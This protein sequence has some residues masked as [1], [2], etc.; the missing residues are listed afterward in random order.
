MRRM[1]AGLPPHISARFL[2]VDDGSTDGTSE[3]VM[4]QSEGLD[5]TVLRHEQPLGPG[6]AFATLFAH[7]DGRI[8]ADDYVA[9]MEGDNTSRL[10]LLTAMFVR[11]REG[12]EVILASP[13]LYGGAIENTTAW[14]VILSRVANV[15]V[16]EVLGLTGLATVSSFYRLYRGSVILELQRCYGPRIV[17]RAGFECMVEMLLKMVYLRTSIS[18]V[19]MTLDTALRAGSSKMKVVRTIV[20]YLSLL[21]AGRR[22]QAAAALAPRSKVAQSA[23]AASRANRA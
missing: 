5:F 17:E 18:E 8:S 23:P 4:R 11:M 16:K 6:R 19:P 21:R 14:R 12:Y 1:A 9:T 20:G 7:L 22:W 15:F 3:A 10:E 13:Y 2:V